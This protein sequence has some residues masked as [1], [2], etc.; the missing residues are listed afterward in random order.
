M[1]QDG[2]PW[3]HCSFGT[4]YR[5]KDGYPFDLSIRKASILE[6]VDDQRCLFK[7]T[8]FDPSDGSPVDMGIVQPIYDIKDRISYYQHL[9]ST[10]QLPMWEFAE[11]CVLG[12]NGVNFHPL[13]VETLAYVSGLRTFVPGMV[14]KGHIIGTDWFGPLEPCRPD[15]DHSQG[16]F[17][18]DVV[19]GFK[20]YRTVEFSGV[21]EDFCDYYMKRQT[22]TYLEGTEYMEKLRFVEDGTAPIIPDTPH[23][24][25]QNAKARAA[26]IR[27]IKH[28]TDFTA[29]V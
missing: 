10:G 24:Q 6:M 5:T 1:S 8:C 17:Q 16:G 29:S 13:L 21:A 18:K 12:T 23:V 25:D 3:V 2:H 26:G 9:D 28:D 11:H 27:F 20:R 22:M 19:D 4:Y 15:A 7:A 14:F